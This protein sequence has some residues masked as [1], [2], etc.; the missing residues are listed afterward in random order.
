MHEVSIAQGML[1]I[2]IENCRKQGCSGI[3]SIKV[4]IGKASGVVPDALLFAFEAMKA[5]TLAE[6]AT[7]IIDQVPI[8]GFCNN[9]NSGFTVDDAYAISCPHCNSFSIRV[10]T[11]REL[12]VDE[13]EVF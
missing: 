11:G 8:S 2:V 5:G 4:K 7:L 6:K 9:C 10:D 13:M 12:N 1:D 3:E